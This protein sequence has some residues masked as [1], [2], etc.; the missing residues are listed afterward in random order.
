MAARWNLSGSY[1]ESCNCEVA[2]PCVFLSAP[3]SGVCDVFLAWH[4]E[5]GR[6]GEVP[7]DG[8]NVALAVHAPGPMTQGKW[9]A[10][11]YLDERA[12][13]AQKDALGQIFGGEAGGEPAALAPLIGKVLG[14]KS[15]KI[16]FRAEGKRRSLRIPKVAEMRIEAIKGQGGK[17]VTLENVPFTAV[18]NQT[19]VVA[20]SEKLSFHDLGF[21][22]EFT[23]KNGFYS[24][25]SFKG[26]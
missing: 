21:D 12:S 5:K 6:H 2:C 24:P 26:P 9:D 25:F 22:W 19:A 7:L 1:F 3:S 15:V 13:S 20:R 18:P 4:I 10:A 8:L 11:L 23:G 14:V 16:E 17:D